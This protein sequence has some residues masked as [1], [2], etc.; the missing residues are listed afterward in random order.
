M[1]KVECDSCGYSWEYSG[2]LLSATCPS[3]QSKTKVE[4]DD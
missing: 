1:S 3:C 2:E 4:K